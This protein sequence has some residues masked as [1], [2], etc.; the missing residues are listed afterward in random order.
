MAL[1]YVPIMI[2][3]GVLS[4]IINFSF[5]PVED[6]NKPLT[7]KERKRLGLKSKILTGFFHTLIRF[8]LIKSE[9]WILS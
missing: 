5:A 7:E 4:L 9:N 2:F 6:E 3:A 1:Y 8:N